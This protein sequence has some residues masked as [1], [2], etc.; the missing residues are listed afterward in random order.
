MKT[1]FHRL[2]VALA[3]AIACYPAIVGADERSEYNQRAASRFVSLFQSL[4]RDMNRKVTVSEAQGDLT[5]MPR[6][7]DMDINRD[8]IV[9]RE[10]LDRFVQLTFGVALARNEANIASSSAPGKPQ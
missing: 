10:E 3:L 1:T 9:T 8:G 7:D 4:D 5:F 6:F 2:L